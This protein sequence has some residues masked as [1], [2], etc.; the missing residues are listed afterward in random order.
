MSV[1]QY[2]LYARENRN[3]FSL[4]LNVPSELVSVTVLGREF[5]VARAE[6]RKARLTKAIQMLHNDMNMCETVFSNA[7]PK[8]NSLSE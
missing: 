3:V 4:D 8:P 5:Q 2:Q 1:V 6:R 7:S